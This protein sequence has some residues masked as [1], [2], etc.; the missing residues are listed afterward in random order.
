MKIII[1]DLFQNDFKTRMAGEKLRNMIIDGVK[2]SDKIE[3]DFHSMTIASISFIDE[4]FIKLFTVEK[5]DDYALEKIKL[6]N[7]NQFDYVLL[8]KM[9]KHEGISFEFKL[10]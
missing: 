7:M 4:A 1:H 8:K 3:I 10:E 6:F 9:L 5:I 2:Q